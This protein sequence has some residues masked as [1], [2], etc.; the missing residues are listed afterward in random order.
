MK[1]DTFWELVE[2]ADTMLPAGRAKPGKCPTSM[3]VLPSHLSARNIGAILRPWNI[4][5]I[6]VQN[7]G[8]K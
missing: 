6:F 2:G 8:E 5:A 1:R 4:L 3:V 7:T